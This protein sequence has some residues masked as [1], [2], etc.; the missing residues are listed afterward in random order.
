L[1]RCWVSI[2]SRLFRCCVSCHS[3]VLV[4]RICWQSPV[5]VLRICWQSSVRPSHLWSDSLCFPVA[6]IACNPRLIWCRLCR[7]CTR[8]RH[9]NGLLKSFKVCHGWLMRLIAGCFVRWRG[10]DPRA[11]EVGFAVDKVARGW[12]CLSSLLSRC[13]CHSTDVSHSFVSNSR[14]WTVRPLDEAFP[15]YIL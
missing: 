4:L 8:T 7:F 10:F 14:G 13:H 9:F 3:P 12:V 1:F 11:V 2:D 6:K 15:R 5:L